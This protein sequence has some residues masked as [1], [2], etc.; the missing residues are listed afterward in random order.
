MKH[1][2]LFP[3]IFSYGTDCTTYNACSSILTYF[4]TDIHK[5]FSPKIIHKYFSTTANVRSITP[6]IE[7]A[8]KKKN[9]SKKKF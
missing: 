6:N 3:D 1:M 5:Y 4:S 2:E 8:R 7:A 9:E